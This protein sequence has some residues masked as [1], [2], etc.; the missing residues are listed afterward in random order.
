MD[1]FNDRHTAQ[2]GQMDLH[3]Q[4]EMLKTQLINASLINELVKV[5]HSCTDLESIVKTVLLS[6]QDLVRFDR[7]I[8]FTVNT[9]RFCLEPSSWVGIDSDVA[10][11]VTAPLGFDGG[12]ITDAIFLNRHIYVEEPDP[13][14]DVFAAELQSHSYIVIPLLK[15]PTRKCWEIRGCTNKSCRCHG[16]VNPYC[17]SISAGGGAPNLSEDERRKRCLMCAAF[18]VEGV[19]WLDRSRSAQ[20]ITS[21]D[22]TNLT[23]I[24]TLSGLVFEN[25]RMMNALDMVNRELMNTNDT[26]RKVNDELEIA[27]AKIRLDLEQARS[28]QQRLLPHNIKSTRDAYRIS[29]QY[30]AANQVGGDYYDMFKIS[31]SAYGLIVADVSG[32]GIASALI[33]SMVKVLLRTF[34]RDEMSPQKTLESINKAFISEVATE[35]FVT[36]FYAVFDIETKKIRYTSSGH[37][38]VPFLNKKTGEYELLKADGLF[39]GVFPDMMLSEKEMDYVPGE[40]RLVLYTDGLTE[41]VNQKSEMYGTER[42]VAT[43][44]ESLGLEPGDAMEAI[45]ESHRVFCDGS[46]PEDD[47]TLLVI[48]F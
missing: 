38:P 48:D 8:L 4:N 15:K 43:V 18:K 7:A 22:I 44:R 37:C 24:I 26:L 17:W 10:R 46:Q 34:S 21:D 6:F 19:F 27:Q 29:S 25:F 16:S 36:V 35:H 20:P 12:D 30:I 11:R 31:D 23:N 42:L 33:M 9:D 40:H 41:T 2:P 5:L 32:H 39:M 47:M 1:N 14:L 45:L 28:I 13:E 3:S